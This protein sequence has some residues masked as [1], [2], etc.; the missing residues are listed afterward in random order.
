MS[1]C[2]LEDVA[3]IGELENLEIL[4]L[5]NSWIVELPKEVGQ[6]THLRLLDLKKCSRVAVIQPNVISSLT[7]LEEL[8]MESSFTN[9][10]TVEVNC[11]VKNA[12]LEE[13]KHLS[14]LTALRLQIR[15]AGILPKDVFNGNFE[16]DRISL[17]NDMVLSDNNPSLSRMVKLFNVNKGIG[18]DQH[19]LQLLLERT[20]DLSL[21]GLQGF[22]SIVGELDE[23]EGFPYLKIFQFKNNTLVFGTSLIRQG[24]IMRT[25]PLKAWNHCIFTR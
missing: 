25:M 10:N 22:N 7:R 2:Y 14:A 5:S 16:R 3:L 18:E 1:D 20:E 12:S 21:I 11:Q 9:W 15:D 19:G 24:K 8:D 6:L 4:D 17:G 23:I 13:L